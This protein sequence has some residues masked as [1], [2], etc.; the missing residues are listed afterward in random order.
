[1]AR[2]N[3]EP[4]ITLGAP[5]DNT[6]TGAVATEPEG[7]VRVTHL[8]EPIVIR[9]PTPGPVTMSISWLSEAQTKVITPEE[10]AKPEASDVAPVTKSADE[11]PA[12]EAEVTPVF[13]APESEAK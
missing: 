11:T 5:T 7:T 13:E 12:E 3:V 8:D 9:Q 2:K 10:P 4:E 6:S 1:M